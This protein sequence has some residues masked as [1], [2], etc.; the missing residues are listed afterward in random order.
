SS[1]TMAVRTTRVSEPETGTPPAKAG[2]AIC[3]NQSPGFSLN[4]TQSV[5]RAGNMPHPPGTS[6][7]HWINRIASQNEGVARDRMETTRMTWS[8]QRSRFRAATTP[9]TEAM[10]APMIKLMTVIC[11]VIG[12]ALI[13]TS[14][15]CWLPAV[16]PRSPWVMKP[17]T[18]LTYRTRRGSLRLLASRYCCSAS[19]LVAG[20]GS[21]GAV[22]DEDPHESD[23][24]HQ[25]RVIEAV[26]FSVLLQCFDA[27]TLAER[28]TGR[29]DR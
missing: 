9:S 26:G 5:I 22:G 1:S 3:C 24:P 8:G 29:V 19:M 17:H 21:Q 11:S 20:R 28:Q 14:V 12:R 16:V 25:E 4:G 2:R 6:A 10:T 18:K 27:G 23:V 7:S 15:T 13:T